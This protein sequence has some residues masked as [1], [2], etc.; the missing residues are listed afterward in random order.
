MA[1]YIVSF[2]EKKA[3]QGSVGGGQEEGDDDEGDDD[4]HA[5]T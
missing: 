5:H 4:L 2:Q 1:V 3:D